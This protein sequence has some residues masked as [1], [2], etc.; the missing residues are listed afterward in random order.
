[1]NPMSGYS[2]KRGLGKRRRYKS[3]GY[4]SYRSSGYSVRRTSA[5]TR[6]DSVVGLKI[7][8][9]AVLVL[10]AA[11]VVTTIVLGIGSVKTGEPLEHSS[12][13]AVTDDNNEELL[14]VVNKTN[15]LER[16]YVPELVELDGYQI[17]PLA[18]DSLKK[19]LS[20][21]ES[22]GIKLSVG[23]AYVSYDDQDKLYKQEYEEYIKENGVSEVKAQSVLEALTPQAG[24]SESQTGL[25][26]YF[27]SGKTEFKSSKAH[28]WLLRNAMKYGFI[29]RYP[30]G[31]QPKTSMHPNSK[32]Y[33]FVG[34]ENARLMNL[35][36]KTLDEYSSYL[37]SR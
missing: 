32:A 27:K 8:R 11:V 12:Y 25:L 23:S 19:L 7:A 17:S 1:M 29:P 22:Q 34:Y 33:R 28:P 9:I 2:K 26:V 3:S 15:P 30:R 21:A 31:S 13:V 18:A 4:S 20:D 5:R 16:D 36:G 24:R 35:L 6:T 37:K 10:L 14:R